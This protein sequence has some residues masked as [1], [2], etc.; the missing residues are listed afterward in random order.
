VSAAAPSLPP[1]QAS[2]PEP[3]F[4]VVGVRAM[5]HAAA[6]TLMIDLQVEEPAG[7][8]VYMIALTIQ[9]I[10]E[11]A[12]RS[13]DAETRERLL[14]LFGTPERWVVSTTNL[15]FAQVDVVVP[16]F[17]GSVTVPVPIACHYDLELAAAKYLQALPDGAAPMALHFNG[18][19]YYPAESGG[20]QMTLVP[21]STSIDFRMPVSVWRETIDHYYPNTAWLGVRTQTLQTLQREKLHRGLPTLDAC[22]SALLEET[23]T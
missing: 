22:L 20:L 2:I 6:P 3:E 19:V 17:T 13:Y 4:Q 5:R 1:T 15:V 7:R 9:V 23:S 12:R 16:A 18:I 10:I 11:P 21:W 8:P 14:E